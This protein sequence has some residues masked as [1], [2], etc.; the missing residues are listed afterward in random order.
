MSVRYNEEKQRNDAADL[1]SRNLMEWKEK[2][3]NAVEEIRK[4][5]KLYIEVLKQRRDTMMNQ[6]NDIEGGGYER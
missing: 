1:Y 6:N 3:E 4:R 5:E 2:Y